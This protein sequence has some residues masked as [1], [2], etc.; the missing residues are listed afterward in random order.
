MRSDIICTVSEFSKIALKNYFKIKESTIVLT[1]NAVDIYEG[2]FIDIR[3]KY[4][5]DKYILFVSRFEPRKN[6]LTLLKAFAE[7]ELYKQGFKLIFIGRYKDV[8]NVNYI[9]YFDQLDKEVQTSVLYFENI[10]NRELANFYKFSDLFVYPSLAEGFGIPPLEAA[11]MNCKVLCSN[12]TAMA[13]FY[14]FGNYLFDPS[15]VDELK[16]KIAKVLKDDSYPFNEI[17]EAVLRNYSWNII[18]HNFG[19]SLKQFSAKSS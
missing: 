17:R 8:Q 14:F 4:N 11:V 16:N 5:L 18:A 9:K 6:H 19:S 12:Q 3:K 10:D 13:D 7:L 15:N 1:P 2:D